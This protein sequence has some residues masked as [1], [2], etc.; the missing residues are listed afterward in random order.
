MEIIPAVDIKNGK[1]V[2]LVQGK[3]GTEQIVIED[4]VEV[5]LHWEKEGAPRLHVIDLDGAIE[6]VRRNVKFIREIVTS[7]SIPV[8]V[9][10]GVRTFEDA[11]SLFELGADRI[12]LGTAAVKNPKLIEDLV[13]KVDSKHVMGA[14]DSKSGKVLIKGWQEISEFSFIDLA[15]IFEKSGAGLILFTNVDVE[16]KLEGPDPE[17]VEEIVRSI[18]IPVIASG[19]ITK[20][21]DIV[22]LTK[23]GAQG[24]VIGLALYKGNFSLKEA[25]EIGKITDC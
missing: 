2:Q 14:V 25:L 10:G 5:A 11:L 8:Q 17:P 13:K 23:A 6:G 21:D 22:T 1:C 4:P 15:K 18:K 12:I 19:G 7:V 24:V 3:P 20:L 16:G 9:G